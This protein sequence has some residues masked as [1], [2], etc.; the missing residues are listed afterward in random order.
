M[1]GERE[2]TY[3]EAPSWGFNFALSDEWEMVTHIG[4]IEE[5]SEFFIALHSPIEDSNDLPIEPCFS[6]FLQKLPKT[7]HTAEFVDQW[8]M[9]RPFM[10][11][12]DFAKLSSWGLTPIY[13]LLSVC[14]I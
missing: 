4:S 11:S 13:L 8:E 1:P 6:V 14:I 12:V 3:I 10:E 9:R 5:G 2:W 7:I